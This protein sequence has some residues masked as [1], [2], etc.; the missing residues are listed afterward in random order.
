MCAVAVSPTGKTLA[1]SEGDWNRGGVVKVIDVNSGKRL[2]RF[3]TRAPTGPE[4]NTWGSLPMDQRGGGETWIAGTYDPQLNLTYWGTAQAKQWSF[5]N[6]G[7]TLADKLLYTSST[8]ALNVDDGKL[9][10][11]HQFAPAESFDLDE[12][13][14]RVLL[15]AG[16]RKLVFNAGKAG[17]LWKMDRQTGEFLGF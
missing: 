10:W 14:E 13:F 4:A 12:V 8:V 3:Q 7:T 17:V 9:A 16:N 2:R 6:R 1:V 5:M 15:D 11:Y